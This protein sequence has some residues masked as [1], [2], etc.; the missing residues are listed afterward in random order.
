MIEIQ[1]KDEIIKISYLD[2]YLGMD[3]CSLCPNNKGKLT[4]CHCTIPYM[5]R[6][7]QNLINLDND[8]VNM[9]DNNFWDLV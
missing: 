7:T 9:V 5:N 1:R 2:Y 3:R 4:F 8:I 6:M